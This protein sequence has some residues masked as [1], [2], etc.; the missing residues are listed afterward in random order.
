MII[1]ADDLGWG[2]LGSFGS[3]NIRTPRLDAMAAEGQKWTNF[4]VQPVCSPS[5]AALLTGRLPIR[6]GMTGVAVR[7]CAEGASRSAPR[8][9]CRP[10]RS[11]SPKL[12]KAKGY[13]TE[14][15]GKWHLGHLPA[16]PPM[17]QG[18]DTWFGL[19]FSHDMRMTAPRE[20]GSESRPTTI[21]SPKYWDVPLMRNGEVVEQPGRSPHADETLHRRGDSIHRGNRSRPFFLYL[22]HNLP[23]IPLARSADFVG[24]SAAGIY[25]DVVE[26]IDASTG[27]VLDALKAAGTRSAHARRVHERQRPVAARS[28]R[29]RIRRAAQGRQRHHVGRRCADAGDFLVARHRFNPPSSPTWRSAMDLFVTTIAACRRRRCRRTDRHRRR[30]SQRRAAAARDAVRGSCCFYYWDNELRADSQGQLQ[31]ALHHAAAPT[32]TASRRRRAQSAAALRPRR[33]IPASDTIVAACI[34][35]VVADL[36]READAHRRSVKAGPRPCSIGL[37]PSHRAAC[38]RMRPR[39]PGPRRGS[40][41]PFPAGIGPPCPSAW[42]DLERLCLDVGAIEAHAAD[43]PRRLAPHAFDVVCGPLCR[44]AFVAL[45]VAAKLARAFSYA[46]RLESDD[47]ESMSRRSLSHPGAAAA[48]TAGK[49]VAIVNDFTSAGSGCPRTMMDARACGG[50]VVV[51][52]SL[53]VLLA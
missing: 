45:M 30:R 36:V 1:L 23:H 6:S 32:A 4:Y 22:A 25:G 3:P 27:R 5:R 28:A 52:G 50:T 40:N 39:H 7:R 10:T 20:N 18:F 17:R 8:R 47:R 13:A 42:L 12:L 46:N 19:P 35:D 48:R 26:E 33:L 37:L 14:I 53:V 2:D 31:G 34:P 16:F 49:R 11:R 41:R 29:T 43:W 38:S 21:R 51:I 9:D 44:G 24:H 15:V